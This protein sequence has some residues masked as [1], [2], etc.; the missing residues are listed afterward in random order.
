MKHPGVRR[1]DKLPAPKYAHTILT[2]F[3]CRFARQAQCE[4]SRCLKCGEHSICEWTCLLHNHSP[5]I[6][7]SGGDIVGAAELSP[8]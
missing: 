2:R 5:V 8:D 6:E 3:T 1:A 4:A 7:R